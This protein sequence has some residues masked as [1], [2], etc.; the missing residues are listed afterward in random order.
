MLFSPAL[1]G[2]FRDVPVVVS[3]SPS[4]DKTVYSVIAEPPFEGAAQ[5]TVSTSCGSGEDADGADGVAGTVVAVTVL[6]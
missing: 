5:L 6:E 3:V 4:L 2:K 1:C